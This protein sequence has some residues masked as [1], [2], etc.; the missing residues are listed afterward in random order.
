ME[1]FE[2]FDVTRELV[3][4]KVNANDSLT[5]AMHPYVQSNYDYITVTRGSD[6][7][8]TVV[9]KDGT[10]FDFHWGYS[11]Y[12]LISEGLEVLRRKVVEFIKR[13]HINLMED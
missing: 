13:N 11:G 4:L 1:V 10:T 8:L 12:T 3:V 7:V 9:K 5:V 6:H 2:V